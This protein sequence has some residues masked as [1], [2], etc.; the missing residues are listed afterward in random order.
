M[1]PLAASAGLLIAAVI[2]APHTWEVLTSARNGHALWL[3][4]NLGL[5]GLGGVLLL[6]YRRAWAADL[7][8][9]VLNTVI[10][11]GL[12]GELAVRTG[13][14][15]DLAGLRNPKLYAGWHYDEE[16]W[17]LHHLWLKVPLPTDGAYLVD[18]QVGWVSAESRRLA[19]DI[20]DRGPETILI[21]GDSFTEGV[22]PTTVDERIPALLSTELGRRAHN[23][24]V[25]GYGI[26]QIY[27]RVRE[28]SG[29]YDR[30]TL[31]VGLLTHDIDRA[32]MRVFS[33]PKPRFEID[34]NGGLS[35]GNVPLPDDPERWYTANPPR[36]RSFLGALLRHQLLEQ[37]DRDAGELIY[38]REEKKRLAT[39]FLEAIAA[40]ARKQDA[41]LVFILYYTEYELGIEGWRERFLK[42]EFDRLGVPL[43]DTKPLFL[44]YVADHGVPMS[45]L[46][47]EPPNQHPGPLGN[48]I[49]A[50]AIADRLRNLSP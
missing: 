4:L 14:H 29:E 46:Y 16:F 33:A 1:P 23:H 36:I 43:V 30:P 8:I 44:N 17:Q 5:V 41:T 28:T 20:G 6:G 15:F 22:L 27:L 34:E 9:V 47:L 48:E 39:A 12:V 11:G 19:E 18:P 2:M 37:T 10:L 21:Y 25:S 50:R 38:R 13:I 7:G 40:L 32:I 3:G 31:V 42:Q 35:L 49:A 24:S 45:A 26:D